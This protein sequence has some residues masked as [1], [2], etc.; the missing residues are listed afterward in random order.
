MTSPLRESHQVAAGANKARPAWLSSAVVAVPGSRANH[1]DRLV[2]AV[3][4]YLQGNRS[5]YVTPDELLARWPWPAT[6]PTARGL[7]N[8]LERL[9]ER[10]VLRHRDGG[11]RV[12]GDLQRAAAGQGAKFKW[13]AQDFVS[14]LS[15]SAVDLLAL[16]RGRSAGRTAPWGEGRDYLAELLG[17]DPRTVA[18]ALRE[19]HK[20]GHIKTVA[21]NRLR[22]GH[23]V[24]VYVVRDNVETT[25]SPGTLTAPDGTL[26]AP[27]GTLTAQSVPLRGQYLASLG[28]FAAPRPLVTPLPETA[29]P[30]AA[31]S[32]GCAADEPIAFEATLHRKPREAVPPPPR[33]RVVPAWLQAEA[34]E[35]RAA[36]AL[37]SWDAFEEHL[38]G[39]VA[40]LH[41]AAYT[42][43]AMHQALLAAGV[44]VMQKHLSAAGRLGLRRRRQGLAEQ[45]VAE[46]SLLLEVAYLRTRRLRMNGATPNQVGADLLA[47]LA[48]KSPEAVAQNRALIAAGK[49]APGEAVG[50][51]ALNNLVQPHKRTV[52]E[53][54]YPTS[55]WRHAVGQDVLDRTADLRTVFAGLPAECAIRED[56]GDI[57]VQRWRNER[58]AA[59]RAERQQQQDRERLAAARRERGRLVGA[60]LAGD[61]RRLAARMPGSVTAADVARLSGI[62]EAEI[63]AGLATLQRGATA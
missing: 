21:M 54:C 36:G 55:W 33:A 26:T 12:D 9:V 37:R 32:R 57:A 44:F 27:R 62:T 48:S 4:G 43:K 34:D 5:R 11:Y 38:A 19:L 24:P 1:L 8:A 20:P 30:A 41:M 16:L 17:A 50:V 31:R 28:S 49:S 10:D 58:G 61:W 59:R 63:V 51:D 60:A 35:A 40:S 56:G 22:T 52:G 13:L 42:P 7:R 29:P 15:L 2:V 18:L 3:L 46:P 47:V 25:H 6:R 45:L 14:G 39:G 53:F 23:S